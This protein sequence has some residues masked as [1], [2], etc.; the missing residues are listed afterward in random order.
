MATKKLPTSWEQVCKI[1][2]ID[3]AQLPD[4]SWMPANMQAYMIAAYKLPI[5]HDVLNEGHV[6]DWTNRSEW[7]YCGWYIMGDG[8]GSGFSFSG[9]DYAYTV[10]FVGARLYLKSGDLVRHANKHFADLYKDY[11]TIPKI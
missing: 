1:K 7:K 3:P 4:V 6:F 2:G 8:T 5:I 11:M 10:S 9:Y